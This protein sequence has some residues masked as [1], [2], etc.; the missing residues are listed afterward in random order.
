MKM[1]VENINHYQPTKTFLSV[2]SDNFYQSD[3][4]SKSNKDF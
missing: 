1:K 4:S 3:I 2:D